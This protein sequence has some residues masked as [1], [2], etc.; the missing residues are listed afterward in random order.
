M[1][2][3]QAETLLSAGWSPRLAGNG[4]VSGPRAGH[5]SHFPEWEC[6]GSTL[7]RPMFAS[8]SPGAHSI[9]HWGC[10]PQGSRHSS[11]YALCQGALFG[12]MSRL[13]TFKTTFGRANSL[14]GSP[15]SQIHT[16]RKALRDPMGEGIYVTSKSHEIIKSL[17][18]SLA[19]KKSLTGRFCIFS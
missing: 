9:R 18:F 4:W 6:L 14:Q 15:H 8:F 13:S 2:Q 10:C 7:I 3:P 12:K 19:S 5:S 17:I 1:E 11:R 16:L